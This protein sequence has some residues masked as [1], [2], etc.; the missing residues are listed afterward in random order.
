MNFFSK[1]LKFFPK[2]KQ[3]LRYINYDMVRYNT[4][5]EVNDKDNDSRSVLLRFMLLS[6]YLP[7]FN[8]IRN[9]FLK[10]SDMFL[11]LINK[12][13]KKF[14][15]LS[16]QK[17]SSKKIY[18]NVCKQYIHKTV[19]VSMEVHQL[20]KDISMMTGYSVSLIIRLILEWEMENHD[21]TNQMGLENS[22]GEFSPLSREPFDS[23]VTKVTRMVVF[24]IFDVISGSVIEAFDI[25]FT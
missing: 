10:N 13:M 9:H 20:L 15:E 12:Y 8:L 19:R 23:V 5:H 4:N 24:H 1:K 21:P 17:S 14:K 2:K 16:E 25:G 3:K 11:Y 22:G 7:M 18:Q 6:G